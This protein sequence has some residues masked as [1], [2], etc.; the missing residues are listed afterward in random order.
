MAARVTFPHIHT[1]TSIF[2]LVDMYVYVCVTARSVNAARHDAL[3][4]IAPYTKNPLSSKTSSQRVGHFSFS[5]NLLNQPALFLL[6]FIILCTFLQINNACA[7]SGNAFHVVGNNAGGGSG[8]ARIFNP[9]YSTPDA[10][11]H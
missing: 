8:A 10:L 6:P 1:H 11:F 2:I 5:Y 9:F 3:P 4:A 7:T